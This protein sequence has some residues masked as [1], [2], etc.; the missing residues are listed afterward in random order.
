MGR[1]RMG[2]V[3]LLGVLLAGC[4]SLL[5]RFEKLPVTESAAWKRVT[6]GADAKPDAPGL[7]FR[8]LKTG[9]TEGWQPADGGS[10]DLP[11]RFLDD[12]L[13]LVDGRFLINRAAGKVIE[14]PATDVA[15]V[16]ASADRLLFRTGERVYIT[17]GAGKRL[18]TVKLPEGA[19]AE[20]L[21][22]IAPDGKMAVLLPSSGG[23]YSVD[24][25]KWRVAKLAEP[26]AADYGPLRSL[27][28]EKELILGHVGG[29]VRYSWEGKPLGAIPGPGAD[30]TFNRAGRRVACA[31]NGAPP[32]VVV[33][34]VETGQAL[35]RV[36]GATAA[37]WAANDSTLVFAQRPDGPYRSVTSDGQVKTV[38]GIPSPVVLDLYARDGAVLDAEGKATTQILIDLQKWQFE[39]V[40]PWGKNGGE[41]RYR[42]QAR[43]AAAA[44]GQQDWPFEPAVQQAPFPTEAW[45]QVVAVP[46]DCLNLRA[47]AGKTGTVIR[48]LS[49][50]TRLMPNQQAGP[51]VEKDGE[52]W[53]S[54][55]TEKGEA[56][57]V[58][59]S[60]GNVGY[61]TK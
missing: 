42:V 50:G 44:Q 15:L 56:G 27:L 11:V 41:L 25:F 60:T 8:D 61:A 58:A 36:M 22:A 48:C 19:A 55:K 53:L 52:R 3:V 2:V 5:D 46:G 9:E 33:S 51:A 26:P 59:I 24:L 40:P 32:Y 6:L 54:V 29:L 18:A 43:A 49:G 57:W 31:A 38:P 39:S 21:G 37:Y 23:L 17:D 20:V 13:I 7:Y 1:F 28:G 12:D 4:S 47:A 34:D 14:W 35:Y 16:A 45:L 10:G 30:C